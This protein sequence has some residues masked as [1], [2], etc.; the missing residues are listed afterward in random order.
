MRKLV[1]YLGCL[2][3]LFVMFSSCSKKDEVVATTQVDNSIYIKTT[4]NGVE[5]SNN[6]DIASST[7]LN[8]CTINGK[9]LSCI[10]YQPVN[11]PF[12][13]IKCAIFVYSKKTDITNTTSGTYTMGGTNVNDFTTINSLGLENFY[14]NLYP[15][16][17]TISG[18]KCYVFKS[19]SGTHKV[20]SIRQISI[21]QNETTYLVA[22][23]FTGIL[24]QSISQGTSTKPIP[25]PTG[26]PVNVTGK[27]QMRVFV[28]NF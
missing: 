14:F 8:I 23:E 26:V 15:E 16:Y 20:T 4:I 25:D 19:G 9:S 17:S 28:N 24:T 13:T 21:T 22:G 11:S 6:E 5:Y 2:V 3:F 1:C 18:S 27:Y 10:N 7:V 12:G